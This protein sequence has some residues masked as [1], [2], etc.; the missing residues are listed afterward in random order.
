MTKSFSEIGKFK[1]VDLFSGLGGFHLAARSYGMKC[2][3]A[4]EIDETLRKVYEKNFGLKPS[5]DIR[6]VDIKKIPAHQIL[7]AGFPC[8]PFSKAGQQLGWRDA[9]RGTLF[10]NIIDILSLH[11]PKYVLLENVAHFVNHDDG[12]TYSKVITALKAIGYSVQSR[13]FSPHQF[14]VPHIRE[15]MYLVAARKSLEDF[16]WPKA[17]S[18]IVD[19]KTILDK[20]PNDAT[21]L[22]SEILSCLRTWQRFL[23]SFRATDKL[24]SFPIWAM[25]FGATYPYDRGSLRRIPINELRRFKGSFGASLKGLERRQILDLLPSHARASKGAFP[26][27]KQDFIEQNRQFY[28]HHKKL[29]DPILPKLKAYPPSWQKLEWN[30]QG[31]SRDI[32]KYVIQFRASGVRVKRPSTSPSLV[33]MTSTQLPIIGWEK[34]FMTLRECK[35]LQSMQGLKAM[36]RREAAFEALGN[37]VNVT[38]VKKLIAAIKKHQSKRILPRQHPLLQSPKRRRRKHQPLQRTRAKY[39]NRKIAA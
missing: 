38:V 17:S 25:E 32:W 20:N 33:A 8:Q 19:L 6:A 1:F 3:F 10:S 24:P 12:N 15:R 34:R 9:V 30:C 11:K 26:K 36:P 5:G 28:K 39:V 29:I 2:V 14:G 23:K 35:R 13:Q 22:K 27:W 4:S 31:E 21:K 37:A 16:E 7:F 18:S